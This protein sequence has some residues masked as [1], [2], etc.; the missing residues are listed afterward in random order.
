MGRTLLALAVLGALGYAATR[1]RPTPTRKKSGNG[2]VEPGTVVDSGTIGTQGGMMSWQVL[3]G[4]AAGTF[5]ARWRMG[6]TGNYTLLRVVPS[7]AGSPILV[8]PSVDMAKAGLRLAAGTALDAGTTFAQGVRVT[9]SGTAAWRMVYESAGSIVVQT[10]QPSEDTYTVLRD[11]NGNV[12]V[13]ANVADA[14]SAIQ[15]AF[16]SA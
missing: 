13:F 2:S 9:P 6:E 12:A 15:A 1:P 14:W 10:K 16:P 4:D 7:D 11:G 3:T 5:L 8:F